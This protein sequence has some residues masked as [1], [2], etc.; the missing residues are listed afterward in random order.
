MGKDHD[1]P[2]EM[3]Q[4][5][6]DNE[7]TEV[8]FF[9]PQAMAFSPTDLLLAITGN[10]ADDFI[11]WQ[12]DLDVT[13]DLVHDSVLIVSVAFSPDGRY[14]A[15]GDDEGAVLLWRIQDMEAQFLYSNRNLGWDDPV[16]G[17]AISPDN[18]L[19]AVQ[20]RSAVK[21]LEMNSGR[22]LYTLFTP[23][24]G[25]DALSGNE[26]VFSADGHYLITG[27][28]DGSVRFWAV[29]AYEPVQYGDS[30]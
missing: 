6:K 12:P 25:V 21:I 24:S 26:V 9:N 3:W 1:T 22:L 30:N 8:P 27:H 11:L 14:L 19:L 17:I 20:S 2:A 10:F 16:E 13:Q 23:I 7:S 29:P 4:T 18:N 15:A 28:R 5:D